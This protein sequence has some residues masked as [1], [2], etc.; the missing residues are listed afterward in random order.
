MN[1]GRRMPDDIERDIREHIEMET[2][3]NVERGMAMLA[4]VQAAN[5]RG[6]YVTAHAYTPAAMQR[7]ILAGVQCIEH[8]QLMDEATARLV[9]EKGIWLSMQPFV[10]L[11]GAKVL[12]AAQQQQMMQVLSGTDAVYGY[13]KKYKIRTVF[14]TDILFSRA[15]AE[16]Q[17]QGIVDLTRWFT[18][19]EA[20]AMATSAGG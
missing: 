13:V 15:L 12:P 10:D 3:D 16:R 18:P 17:G 14:G 2:R 5:D 20:L 4:A 19:A 7:A 6:T 8:G 11:G 9:A 1:L